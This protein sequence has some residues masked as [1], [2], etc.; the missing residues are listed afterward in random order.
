MKRAA[1]PALAATAVA[2][3]PAAR[4]TGGAPPHAGPDA[5]ALDAGLALH[6]R[7][8]TVPLPGEALRVTDWR[9]RRG[10]K[11][12][13]IGRNGVGKTSLTE[14]VLGLR[15]GPAP[16]GDMLGVPL[17]HWQR[18]P[19]LRKQL[20][21]QLQRVFFPGR[22]RVSELVELH[23]KLY[24]RTSERVVQALG[25]PALSHRLYEYLSRGE[26][27]RVDLFL[28]L[29]HEP[30]LLFLDEPFTGL[31]PQFSRRLGELL[32]EL[33]D[34]T[35]I[36]CCHTPDELDLATHTAWLTRKGIAR[37]G[38]THELRRALVGEY[39]LSASCADPASAGRLAALFQQCEGLN[40]APQ[41]EE[42][43]F[44]LVS[45]RPLA[46]IARE[47][48]DLPEVLS[49]DVGRTQLSDLLRHCSREH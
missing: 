22:P 38:E 23:R 18:R 16:D 27:Q 35:L 45:G 36:M 9:V 46:D 19:Q 26:T 29:A 39:H 31:D 11:V 20:G 48:V 44:S 21:V 24:D 41:V 1:N 4:A 34:T 25:I 37:Y 2:L 6:V 33:R 40:S 13:V 10:D 47:L 7:S 43:R 5:A 30:A 28:A 3:A 8:L 15:S 32:R 12:A 17:R 42:S 14:A 49:V